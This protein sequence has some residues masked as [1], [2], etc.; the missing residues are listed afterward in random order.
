MRP[1]DWRRVTRAVSEDAID[2][3]AMLAAALKVNGEDTSGPNLDVSVVRTL[4][5]AKHGQVWNTLELAR[6][7]EVEAFSAPFV[8]ARRRSDGIRGTLVF[9]HEP[10][11]YWGYKPA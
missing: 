3:E 7:F 6:D 2:H 5:E 4:L 10:R 9:Q 1:N 11:F 8:V